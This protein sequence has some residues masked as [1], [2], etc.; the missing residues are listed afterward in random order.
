MKFNRLWVSVPFQLS[1]HFL[2][3]NCSKQKFLFW[4]RETCLSVSSVLL[5][6]WDRIFPRGDTDLF[7]A[8]LY[9][10]KKQEGSRH[11]SCFTPCL[12]PLEF[13]KTRVTSRRRHD[14]NDDT[15]IHFCEEGSKWVSLRDSD[16][17][18]ACV[19]ICLR[20]QW[21]LSRD[22]FSCKKRCFSRRRLNSQTVKVSRNKVRRLQ[23]TLL[24]LSSRSLETR[25]SKSMMRKSREGSLDVCT[26]ISGVLQV[27]QSPDSLYFV[28]ERGWSTWRVHTEK[29][30]KGKEIQS[31]ASLCDWTPGRLQASKCKRK[32]KRCKRK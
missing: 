30:S 16:E 1:F 23:H 10:A 3:S 7:F 19:I 11:S 20:N 5:I 9:S 18:D 21:C 15:D 29:E 6:P 32:W 8:S 27:V 14:N 22:I 4:R 28:D 25:R 2:F 26:V 12:M 13:V 17:C 24:K 31:R